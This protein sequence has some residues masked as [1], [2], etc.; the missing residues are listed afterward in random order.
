[1]ITRT[2]AVLAAFRDSEEDLGVTELAGRLRLSSSTVHRIVR[3]LA[4][5]G[6]LA[7]NEESDRY[8]LGRESVLL[9]QVANRRLGLHLVQSVLER[10]VDQTGESVNLGVRDGHEMVVV[11][12]TESSQP[13]RFSQAPGSRLPVHA[14]GMGKVTLAHSGS[15]PAEVSA[16]PRPLRPLTA[17]TIT[18]VRALRAELELVGERGFSLDDEEA[19]AGVRCV[20]VPVLSPQGQVLAALAIQAPAVRMPLELAERLAPVA[21]GAAREIAGMIPWGHRL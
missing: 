12:R 14:T 3:A 2:L 5:E 20:A 7:Q 9:G 4:H 15:V 6:Y 10:L 11:I 21:M 17:H 18:S 19:I 13:L 16:L 1:M 8:Y